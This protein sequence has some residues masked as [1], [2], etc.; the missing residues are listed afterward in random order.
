MVQ[1]RFRII[2]TQYNA[3]NYIKKCLDSV[4]S[5]TY[6]NYEIVVMDDCS[7]DGT[8]DIIQKYPVYI[9][10]TSVNT[11]MPY[12][13][14]QKAI[15]MFPE[16]KE[17]ILVFLSGDDYF[18]SNDVLEHLNQVYQDDIWLTYGQYVPLSNGYGPYCKPLY[19]TRTYRKSGAWHTSHLI[20]FKKWLWDLIKDEDFKYNGEYVRYGFDRAFMYP[21]IEMAGLNHIRFI[22]KILYIYNDQNPTCLFKV[23]P[24]ESIKWAN[25]FINKPSYNEL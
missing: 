24:S 19:D 11:F 15:K 12:I 9:I 23:N 8:L 20:T 25:Y 6:K 5:Q 21:M 13:N 1:N 17:D 22:E 3:V 2:V 4:M 18:A 14:F 7:T 10:R 16:N